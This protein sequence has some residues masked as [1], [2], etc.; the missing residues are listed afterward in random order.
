MRIQNLVRN[1]EGKRPIGRPT[2]RWLANTT[3][4]LQEVGWKSVD[5]IHRAAS[6]EHGTETLGSI[7]QKGVK[8]ID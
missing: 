2:R 3:T 4:G 7:V 8:F 5:W 1:A 6:C